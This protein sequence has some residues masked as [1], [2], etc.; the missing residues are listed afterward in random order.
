MPR[1]CGTFGAPSYSP[2]RD[3]RPAPQ[4]SQTKRRTASRPGAAAC[5]RVPAAS[6]FGE[7][8]PVWFHGDIAPG[9]LLVSGRESTSV[10]DS[11]TS[12]VGDPTCDLI[13]AVIADSRRTFRRGRPGRTAL[14][15]G[16]TA[17]HRA[18]LSTH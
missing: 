7:L 10:I 17:W 4:P 16:R 18:Q 3:Y 14:V 15:R 12:G 6:T 11:G 5:G 8:Q 1:L 2:A 13:L 9:N